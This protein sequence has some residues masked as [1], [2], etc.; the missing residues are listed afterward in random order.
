VSGANLPKVCAELVL[1]VGYTG[2]FHL[3]IIAILTSVC[4]TL[5]AIDHGSIGGAAHI[6]CE[7]RRFLG[8][9]TSSFNQSRQAY[10]RLGIGLAG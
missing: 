10:D 4:H 5:G 6:G 7:L 8:R 9:K 2:F 3:A 1:Q